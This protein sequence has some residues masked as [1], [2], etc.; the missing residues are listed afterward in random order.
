MDEWSMANEEGQVVAVVSYQGAIHH[1]RA[2]RGAAPRRWSHDT[3][4]LPEGAT[5][6]HLYSRP[7]TIVWKRWGFVRIRATGALPLA[8]SALPF[9]GPGRAAVRQGTI[10]FARQTLTPWLFTLPY[11]AWT[12]P[13]WAMAAAA[14]VVPALWI[15]AVVRRIHRRRQGR[16][17]ACGYDLRASTDRCPECGMAAASPVG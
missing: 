12:V 10:V 17:M 4:R 9:G 5:W 8:R 6:A 2:G 13:Y 3:Y 14:G 7:G 1:I 16:C 15:S 11:D